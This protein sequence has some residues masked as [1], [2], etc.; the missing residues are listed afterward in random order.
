[1]ATE[2]PKAPLIE[3]ENIPIL[4][5]SENFV[6]NSEVTSRITYNVFIKGLL[7]QILAEHNRRSLCTKIEVDGKIVK[8]WDGMTLEQFADQPHTFYVNEQKFTLFWIVQPDHSEAEDGFEL[9]ANGRS[10]SKLEFLNLD[11]KMVDEEMAIFNGQVR[12]NNEF[13]VRR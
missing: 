9:H 13:V 3:K 4:C 6:F 5:Q 1:M 12:I 10:V 11:F 2:L 7:S 8:Q